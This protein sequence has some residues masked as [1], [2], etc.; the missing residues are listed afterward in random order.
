MNSVSTKDF[1]PT[2]NNRITSSIEVLD[3][4]CIELEFQG[5]FLRFTGRTEALKCIAE[6]VRLALGLSTSALSQVPEEFK[7]LVRVNVDRNGQ[8]LL[9]P[10]V[11]VTVNKQ[12]LDHLISLASKRTALQFQK[13]F[14][15]EVL[16][17]IRKTA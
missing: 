3:V 5:K 16:P 2:M 7:G 6:D 9:L 17:Y 4:D 14:Y 15:E 11:V 13:W 1:K 12:G 8:Q 10:D